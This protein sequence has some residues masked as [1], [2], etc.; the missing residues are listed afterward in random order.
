[1]YIFKF[2]AFVCY[3]W[4][5]H[6]LYRRGLDRHHGRVRLVHL[7]EFLHCMSCQRSS[8]RQ[9]CSTKQPLMREPHLS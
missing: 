9:P 5:L 1:M 4:I 7:S 3:Q 2:E 8:Y 6:C